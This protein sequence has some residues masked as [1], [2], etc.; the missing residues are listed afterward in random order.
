MSWTKAAPDGSVEPGQARVV[1]VGGERLVLCRLSA[2]EVYAVEDTCSHD[3]GSLGQGRLEG[4]QIECPRH[5]ARFDVRTGAATRMPAA[6]PIA[7]FPARLA[8]GWIEVD[9]EAGG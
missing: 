4:G 3:D 1:S 8:D 2:S 7:T 5:G 9:L 6:S